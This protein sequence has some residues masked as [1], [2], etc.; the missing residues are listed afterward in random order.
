MRLSQATAKTVTRGLRDH[1]ASDATGIVGGIF[2]RLAADLSA[3]DFSDMAIDL[4]IAY[5][6]RCLEAKLQGKKPGDKAW[7]FLLT[8]LGARSKEP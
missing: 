8:A 6:V 7:P 4:A 1:E 5:W 3:W 2:A